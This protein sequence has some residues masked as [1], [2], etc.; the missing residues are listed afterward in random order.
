MCQICG[1]LG[2]PAYHAAHMTQFHE[3]HQCRLCPE[4]VAGEKAYIEHIK[5]VHSLVHQCSKCCRVFPSAEKVAKHERSCSGVAEEGGV[6]TTEGIL[7]AVCGRSYSDK[8]K[9]KGHVMR[10]HEKKKLE[11]LCSLC[12]KGFVYKCELKYHIDAVHEHKTKWV[13]RYDG[14]EASYWDRS[15][16]YG[17]ERKVHGSN[18]TKSEA[19]SLGGSKGNGGVEVTC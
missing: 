6:A 7:C 19:H 10:V 4:A 14:C 2:S 9:L 12:G 5:T 16:M 1:T 18:F 15:S 3:E 17:H 8:A 13:C 11:H